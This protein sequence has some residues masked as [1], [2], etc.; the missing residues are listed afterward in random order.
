M[1]TYLSSGA[2]AAATTPARTWCKRRKA[3]PFGGAVFNRK[4]L[5][6]KVWLCAAC[7]RW[8]VWL[9]DVG[10][11]S[12]ILNAQQVDFDSACMVIPRPGAFV[13]MASAPL[14][15]GTIRLVVLE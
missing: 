3:N 1:T 11:I 10:D 12:C 2:G 8:A 5:P 7:G 15:E 13:R 14:P 9:Y 6:R 4:A